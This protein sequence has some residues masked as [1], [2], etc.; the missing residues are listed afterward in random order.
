M[1]D[2]IQDEY[3][4]RNFGA[5]E[6]EG[7]AKRKETLLKRALELEAKCSTILD[8]IELGEKTQFDDHFGKMD[9]QQI[10]A[11]FDYAMFQYSCGK[12]DAVPH[13]L[14]KYYIPNSKNAER[15]HEAR[16]GILVSQIQLGDLDTALDHTMP[17][18]RNA[19][20]EREKE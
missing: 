1:I 5:K 7:L 4:R 12:Y 8:A 16:W 13:L 10:E 19:I 18:L 3:E 17:E 6:I 20:Q 15:I 14:R 2:A 11:L 9:N